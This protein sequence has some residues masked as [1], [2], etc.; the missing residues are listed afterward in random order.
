MRLDDWQDRAIYFVLL[1]RFWNG[2]HSNDDQGQ[3]E[4]DPSN[5]DCFQGGDLK[6]V[7]E[8]LPHIKHLGF[9]A[10]WIT[11]PVRNQW[12]NPYIGTRGYHGYWA[13]D[14]TKI[15]PHFGALED[16]RRLVKEAHKRGIKVIQDIVVNHT[17]N[18][19]TV[20]EKLYDPKRPERAWK[21]VVPEAPDDPVFKLNN[22][23]VAEHKK[24]AVYN[25]TPNISDFKSRKQTLTYAMGDLDDINLKSPLVRRRFREIYNYWIDEVGV[26]GFRVD[27]VYY[28]PE[29]F[30][31]DFLYAED[32]ASPGVKRFAR[33][34]GKDDFFVFGEVWSYDYAAV[35]RYLR[36]GKTK[37]LD[38]AIDHPLNEALAQV[39]Y[40][41]T[42]TEKLSKPLAA[43]RPNANFWVNFLDNHDVERMASRAPW[44]CVRQSLAALFT[45]PGIPCVYY[46]TEAGLTAPRQNMFR[47]EYFDEHLERAAFLKRLVRFRKAHPALSRGRCKVEQTSPECGLLSYSVTRGKE[48]YLAVF[49]TSPDRM[50]YRLDV[51]RR[52]FTALLG[53]EPALPPLSEIMVLA[54]DSFLI[55]R[56]DRAAVPARGGRHDP[57]VMRPLKPGVYRGLI[58][59]GFRVWE[60]GELESLQLVSNGNLD[61]AITVPDP[62][63][64]RFEVDA[65]ELGNGEHRLALLA[66][67]RSGEL[68][69]SFESPI[70]VRNPYRLI[71]RAALAPE[72]K[73]GLGV[74]LRP[75]A[76]P[77]YDGQTSIEEAEVYSSGR[78]LRLKL[79]MKS[80]TSDW[81]PPNGFDHVYFHVFFELPG[82]PGKK[83]FPKL[84][85]GR[86]D[87]SF[88]LGFQL[89]GWG[90]RS[91]AAADS[92]PESFGAPLIGEIQQ[93]VDPKAGTIAFTFSRRFFDGLRSFEG[94]RIYVATWDGYLGEPRGIA[95]AKEDWN[96]YT[97]GA[98]SSKGLP[99]IF[100]HVLVRL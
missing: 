81:N 83:F 36:S 55:L 89:H 49:N 26:D 78:D 20:D 27:T 64:G 56:R 5:D 28:T 100:D 80:V 19:F 58:P 94:V 37:R 25:F 85:Y 90:T 31:E 66:R 42:A 54:P 71:A 38:S 67:S 16:Y 35:N 47:E 4:F 70:T 24:A 75:P 63:S 2:D 84:D 21:A 10:L 32:R 22:P 34:K 60:P 65:A 79:R 17:G 61:R 12:V 33:A 74:K 14:F 69:L 29:D 13:S 93:S 45:L 59:I 76:E 9:D 97:V 44:P 8:K 40:R 62:A 43:E 23:N 77:S 99:K 41:K 98:T 51:R 1:D 30:Y 92:T 87:F 48:S 15:D 73:A 3:G 39:F 50:V 52:R 46:G 82:R 72:N 18:F 6:G 88:C 68:A 95:E 7:I 11:P 53:S 96:F 91:F 57:V 86:D